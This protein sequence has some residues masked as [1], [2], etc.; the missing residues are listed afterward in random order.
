LYGDI[1]IKPFKNTNVSL[2]FCKSFEFV[3]F[4]QRHTDCLQAGRLECRNTGMLVGW[5]A[6]KQTG[7]N[8]DWLIMK[9]A[10]K[11]AVM[12]A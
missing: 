3:A 11:Q 7:K 1:F 4:V 9:Q 10:G 5:Q 2:V 12:K 6:G 8:A